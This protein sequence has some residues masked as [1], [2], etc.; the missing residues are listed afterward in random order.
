MS[1]KLFV[2]LLLLSVVALGAL[3]FW[4]VRGLTPP[5]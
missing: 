1:G 3:E 2:S 5:V 4:L